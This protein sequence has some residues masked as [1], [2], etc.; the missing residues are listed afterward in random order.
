MKSAGILLDYFLLPVAMFSICGLVIAIVYEKDAVSS[1]DSV[2]IMFY[3]FVMSAFAY[4]TGYKKFYM[5]GR[6]KYFYV[7]FVL[8]TLIASGVY[9][10]R[11]IQ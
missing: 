8:P 10:V 7:F 11:V 1:I 2:Y 9:I 5:Y 6:K 4:E 3:V